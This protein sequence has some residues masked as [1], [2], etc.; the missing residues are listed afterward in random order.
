MTPTTAANR[1]T[2]DWQRLDTAHYLHPFTDFRELGAKGARIITRAQGVYLWDSDGHKTLDAMSGLWCVNVGYGR[3]ELAEAAYRQMLE[4]PFY[5]SFFQCAHPPA[6]ELARVLAE[7]TPPGFKHVFFTG[8]GSEAIDTIVRMVRH[9]WAAQGQPQRSVIISR[10]NA[11]HGS[12]VAGASLGGMKPMHAQGGLPIPDIVHIEQPYWYQNG[13][14][15]SPE[16]FGLKA[17]A[18]LERKILELGSNRVAAFIGE[19]IQGAGGVII[20]PRTYWPEIE[21]ICRQYG[22]LLVADEVICGFGRIGEWFGSTYF[23][24][25]P[26]LMAIAKGLSSGYLPIGGV[27][28]SDAVAEVLIARGGEF[29]HG[30]TYSGHPASCA[31][32]IANIDILRRERLVERARTEI[33]PYLAKRWLELADHPLVGEARIAGMIGALEL[34]RNKN[35]RE[36]FDRRGEVGQICRDLCIANGLVMRA[37]RDSMLIAPPLV[38]STAEV[39]E[40]IEKACRSLDMT[41]A[42]VRRQGRL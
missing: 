22:I 39:D 27:L 37:T 18:A 9:Y 7:V 2:A 4:L 11:Y 38:I 1:S 13:G 28:V 33:G 34:V 17:A 32:A 41:L 30:F 26:D 29:H 12:T 35:S 24:F 10:E 20:P 19:P 42:E 3:K 5:N 40:L 31:V 14:E 23:G 8:S 25:R 16:E 21:R 36:F 15:L 6:I